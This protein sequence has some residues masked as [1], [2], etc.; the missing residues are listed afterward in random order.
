MLPLTWIVIGVTVI[1]SFIANSGGGGGVF[2]T[3]AL[4][5][6]ALALNHEWYRLLSVV[7]VHDG[8]LHLFFNMYALWIL[9]P[10]VEGIWGTKLFAAFYVITAIAAS[11]ASFVT[12]PI[13]AVGASGAIFGLI[14]VV[15][16]GTRAHH[17]ILDVRA[18]GIVRQLGTLIVLNL[19]I[20]FLAR[21]I[22]DNAAHI[23]GFI[24]G[25]WLGFV[26]PPGRSPTLRSIWQ[27]PDGA[28]DARPMILVVAGVVLL[29][30][31]I[32]A[33][34]AIGPLTWTPADLPPPHL[35]N[36]G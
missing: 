22:I 4:D 31:V 21:D 16:A 35:G 11:T 14:G 36:P 6:G 5:K 25:L 10:L 12:N 18:R 29:I 7:L 15:F 9:G 1:T 17:P 27:R 8:A 26:V 34:L 20:G 28:S 32:A 30:A 24:A 2:D 33:A 19:A 23:G 3:L 13:P